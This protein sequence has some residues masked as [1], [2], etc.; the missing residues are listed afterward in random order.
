ML[1]GEDDRAIADVLEDFVSEVAPDSTVRVARDGNAVLAH[2]RQSPP[3]LLLL[4][5]GLP[6]MNGIE[7]CMYLRGAGLA[8]QTDIVALSA[9]AQPRDVAILQ[10]LGIRSFIRK[11]DDW[12]DRVEDAVHKSRSSVLPRPHRAR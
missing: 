1:I 11:G 12:L 2:V 8:P 7:L 4:D 9:A 5:I 6:S 10:Q 3:D